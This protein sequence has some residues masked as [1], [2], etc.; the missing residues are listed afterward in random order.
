MRCDKQHEQRVNEILGD[1]AVYPWIKDDYF[2]ERDRYRIGTLLIAMPNIYVLMPH[3]DMILFAEPYT[4]SIFNIHIAVLPNLRGIE[5]INYVIETS[6]WIFNNTSC[7]KIMA[8]IPIFNK[9]AKQFAINCGYKRE[10]TLT[11]SFYKNGTMQDQ[12]IYGITMEELSC[13]LE[14]LYQ[15]LEVSLER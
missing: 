5:A 8:L 3:K 9:R 4:R 12:A 15:Q 6:R 1:D 7:K 11:K 13:Q 2:D 14:K 10:G